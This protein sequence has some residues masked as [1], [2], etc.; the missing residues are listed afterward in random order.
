MAQSL[1]LRLLFLLLLMPAAHAD[2]LLII[3]TRTV[4]TSYWWMPRERAIANLI[5]FS[6]GAGGIGY[7]EGKPQ[8]GNFLIRSREYFATGNP[9][10]AFNVALMGNASDMR[11]LDDHHRVSREHMQDIAAVIAQIRTQNAL[12]IWLIGT[13]LGTISAAAAAI[14]LGSAVDGVVLTS[15]YV[16]FKSRYSVP[17]Q[18]LSK[19]KIPILVMSHEQDSCRVTLPREMKYIMENLT[20]APIKKLLLLTGGDN[21]RGDECGAF[22]W[23]GFIGMEARA[24][25]VVTDWIRQPTP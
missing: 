14:E 1:V 4:T 24:A 20:E 22:H 12:P 10:A 21:P 15:S 13:S 19:I 18:D 9:Q 5:L 17:Q 7:R 23:H 16:R 25:N 2:E 6:G 11:Q 3:P 8:S